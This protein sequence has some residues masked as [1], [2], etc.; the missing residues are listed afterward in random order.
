M[1]VLQDDLSSLL[2][3]LAAVFRVRPQLWYD[4]EAPEAYPYISSFMSH[5]SA[6]HGQLEGFLGPQ[7][8]CDVTMYALPSAPAL[9]EQQQALGG[10][11]GRV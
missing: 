2:D 10:S 8:Q 7:A 5:V 6:G 1:V 3:A 9:Q 4:N 11:Y